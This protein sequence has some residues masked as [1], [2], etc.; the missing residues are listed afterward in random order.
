MGGQAEGNKP[1]K[2]AK[3]ICAGLLAHVDTGK[4]TLSEALLYESG[5]IRKAGRVDM[6]TRF[7]TTL[8]W[9]APGGSRFF[10]SRRCWISRRG[11]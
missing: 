2:Q 9:S 7:W 3:L 1:G 10:P 6:E 11:K 4:T 5:M 8:S